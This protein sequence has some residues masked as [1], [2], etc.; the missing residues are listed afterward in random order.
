MKRAKL[1]SKPRG[2]Q[3][4]AVAARPKF[5]PTEDGRKY[6][7]M[8]ASHGLTQEEICQFIKNPETD[9]PITRSTLEQY[10]ARE[11]KVGKLSVDLEVSKT[12]V[13]KALG[14]SM[15]VEVRTLP[16][17]VEA[18]T[19][20]QAPV[21]PDMTALIWYEKTRRGFKEG[22]TL[23]HMGKDGAALS[24][25]TVVILPPNG[26]ETGALGPPVIDVVAEPEAKKQAVPRGK[27]PEGVIDR[28]KVNRAN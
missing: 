28:V 19:V 14:R 3:E 12:L 25:Q 27:P 10:F 4:Q 11:L 2:K 16:N 9:E 21:A 8:L 6:V 26:R 1:K 13:D 5:E 7:E 20:V 22:M 23:E 15:V 17:G 18:R 24:T